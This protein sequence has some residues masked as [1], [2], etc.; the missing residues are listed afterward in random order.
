MRLRVSTF[1]S[2]YGGQA[3]LSTPTI[4]GMNIQSYIQDKKTLV[5]SY[6][7]AYLKQTILP[8]VSPVGKWGNDAINRILPFTINGKLLRSSLLFLATESFSEQ[9]NH[10]ITI[11]TAAAIELFQTGLLI[12][13]DIMDQDETRRGFD[14]MHIQY[15]NIL[16]QS[17]TKNPERIGESFALQVGDM[18][19]FLA[20]HILSTIKPD[21]LSVKLT[22]LF[23]TELT[24]VCA[25]QMQDVYGG[26]TQKQRPLED[27]L[28][29]YTYKTGR[30]SVGLPL[31]AAGIITGVGEQ[32]IKKL[33]KMGTA[34]GIVY[35]I[36]DDWLNIY[37]DPEK[38]GKPVGSDIREGKQTLYFF[39][40][41]N[42][43]NTYDKEKLLQVFGNPN[44]SGKDIN[45]I[46]K[47]II[48][49]HIDSDIHDIVEKQEKI[50]DEII[51]HLPIAGDN[52]ITL[53]DF[54]EYLKN[55][56]A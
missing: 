12:H 16:E 30:Y 34:L 11:K 43:T 17:G 47:Q 25:S 10:D 56:D 22:N 41:M 26:S 15:K 24:K 35:Q 32:T 14:S 4:S 54:V 44:L 19:F 42:K 33:W 53:C 5:S 3:R 39:F 31:V 49:L 52:R 23:T 27:I 45:D 51:A 46:Q 38:T 1:A 21:N 7:Q 29:V 50:V 28:S 8:E 6:L 37:G 18:T 2:S 55:R 20:F 13:D 48:D 9:N 40:L 36:K